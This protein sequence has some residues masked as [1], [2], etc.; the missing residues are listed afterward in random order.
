MSFPLTD[1][2][3]QS[4]APLANSWMWYIGIAAFGLLVP[5]YAHF[6][7]PTS[8]WQTLYMFCSDYTPRPHACLTHVLSSH[9]W[10]WSVSSPPC[11]Q[12]D[13]VYRY[14]SVWQS[15]GATGAWGRLV[16]LGCSALLQ[17]HE[18]WCLVLCSE[19]ELPSAKSER[20]NLM[21]IICG[22]FISWR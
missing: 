7:Y 12:L 21:F 13:V 8:H 14:S 18:W 22:S 19:K 1:D 15:F 2:V 4:A 3:D 17:Q 16:F 9:R 5:G 10:C 11:K 6:K 20:V